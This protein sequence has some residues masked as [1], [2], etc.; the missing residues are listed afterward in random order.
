MKKPQKNKKS[1]NLSI[2][3]LNLIIYLLVIYFIYHSLNGERGIFAYQR[4]SKELQTKREILNKLSAEKAQLENKVKLIS[5]DKVDLDM[6][7]ELARK[8]LGLAGKNDIM[9]I[10]KKDSNSK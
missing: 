1:D 10:L 2:I 5:K 4:L 7:D 9:I 6:L 8:K 3:G